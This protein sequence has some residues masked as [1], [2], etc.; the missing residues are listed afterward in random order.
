MSGN[1]KATVT[2]ILILHT[3][4][5]AEQWNDLSKV[6]QFVCGPDRIRTSSFQ[7]LPYITL[8][9]TSPQNK[10]PRMA[11]RSRKNMAFKAIYAYVE[12]LAQAQN[13]HGTLA[14]QQNA[15]IWEMGTVVFSSELMGGQEKYNAHH[16]QK[17]KKKKENLINDSS[18]SWLQ[19][20]RWLGPQ[21]SLVYIPVGSSCPIT[22]DGVNCAVGIE[23][24][25]GILI[26]RT[27]ES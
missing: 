6:T 13:L 24:H 19:V 12:I 2:S 16:R 18:G 22:F 20:P 7:H 1:L 15:S 4:R 9:S 17:K 14:H 26:A 5:G 3:H 8:P 11:S 21:L 23:F 10:G 27:G 25:Q